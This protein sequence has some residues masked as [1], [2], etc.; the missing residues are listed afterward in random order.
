MFCQVCNLV[1]IGN[2]RQFIFIVIMG[3]EIE[4]YYEKRLAKITSEKRRTA[5]LEE[6]RL[7]R[8]LAA[9]SGMS[10]FNSAWIAHC[11]VSQP[12]KKLSFGRDMTREETMLAF[13]EAFSDEERFIQVGSVGKVYF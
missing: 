11:I 9:L 6:L 3:A 2:S 1:P 5:L 12:G 7:A 8:E 4:S 13:P 10:E